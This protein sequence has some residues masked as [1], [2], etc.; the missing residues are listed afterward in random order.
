[1]TKAVHFCMD[2]WQTSI[3]SIKYLQGQNREGVRI[4]IMR[5]CSHFPWFTS[6]GRGPHWRSRASRRL[7]VTEDK[8]ASSLSFNSALFFATGFVNTDLVFV[9]FYNVQSKVWKKV[10]MQQHFLCISFHCVQ[11]MS[12]SFLVTL[13]TIVGWNLIGCILQLIIKVVGSFKW[14]TSHR[15][16]KVSS[17]KWFKILLFWSKPR[18][19]VHL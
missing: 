2:H 4:G 13:E 14:Q 11:S 16:H 12:V 15:L 17:A 6:E 3:N 19:A 8:S 5:C 1:M 10:E 7:W 18:E 9:E